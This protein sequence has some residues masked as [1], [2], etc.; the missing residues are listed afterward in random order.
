MFYLKV[1][2][3]DADTN[4]GGDVNLDIAIEGSV[5]VPTLPYRFDQLGPKVI[6]RR[7]F[8]AYI[9]LY[10]AIYYMGFVVDFIV[11]IRDLLATCV[12]SK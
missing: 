10:V 11:T 5:A 6:V 4:L 1:Q 3:T 12:A 8:H 7:F 9:L 2:S